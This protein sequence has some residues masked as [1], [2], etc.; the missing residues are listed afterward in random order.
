MRNLVLVLLISSVLGIGVEAQGQNVEPPN[1]DN[2]VYV[3]PIDPYYD[4]CIGCSEW[5][6]KNSYP[7]GA[8]PEDLIPLKRKSNLEADANK[9]NGK[10][11]PEE[12][13]EVFTG[14]TSAS[15]IN[16]VRKK[17]LEE[18]HSEEEVNKYIGQLMGLRPPVVSGGT[19]TEYQTYTEPAT[20]QNDV[21]SYDE[22]YNEEPLPPNE[23]Y[24]EE[25]NNNKPKRLNEDL[26]SE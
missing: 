20:P 24:E 9:T 16:Q 2:T 15:Y 22:S 3:V 17:L 12:T 6:L 7:R 8:R 10:E 23:I 11:E 18:G 5:M 1:E 19:N 13:E 4:P 26:T 25:A 14:Y 21:E